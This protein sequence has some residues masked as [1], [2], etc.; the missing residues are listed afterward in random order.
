MPTQRSNGIYYVKRRLAGIGPIY[1]SL[2]TRNKG[3]AAT[4]EKM[5][6]SLHDQGR[7]DIVRAFAT[8]TTSIRV[9]AE[10]Y[11]LSTIH[12]L[13]TALKRTDSKLSD[14]CRTTLPSKAPDVQATTLE[15]YET[16]LQHFQRFAGPDA[17]VSAVL[18]EDS[19][20]E[21]KSFRLAEGAKRET[22]NNDC[23]AVSI[24]CAHARKKGW[25]KERVE[26]KRFRPQE[27]IRYLEPD[28]LAAY[29][30]LLRRPF[31]AQMQLL[32]GTGM[33]L[34]ESEGLRVCDLRF[35]DED[36]RALITDAKTPTGVR[37]VF[38]PG[39][40]AEA[41]ER[42]V[43]EHTLAGTETIFTIKRRVVQSEHTRT[44]KLA[45]IHEYTIHD[46]RHTAAVALARAG[47]PLH[48]LQRQ[49]GHKNIAM[50]MRYATFNPEYG[51]VSRYFDRVSDR[52]GLASGNTSGNTPRTVQA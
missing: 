6:V 3:R 51:D 32:V 35:E 10:H 13:A 38:V 52:F 4:L 21:F 45:G 1:R 29:M 30:A 15:R 44:C 2:G 46:H 19:V 20:Q 27:R 42:H 23:A 31:R 12:D 40:A 33:R 48:L 8:G 16:G 34:G 49:L 37:P 41:V 26:I 43:E 11:E 28:Q 17:L 24:L 39:W 9:I 47:M 14:A 25:L 22:V 5:L 36:R 7:L 18:T 50:T